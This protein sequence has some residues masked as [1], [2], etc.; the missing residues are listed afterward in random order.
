MALISRDD[1]ESWCEKTGPETP[2]L[3]TVNYPVHIKNLNLQ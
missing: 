3:D 2:L 1:L